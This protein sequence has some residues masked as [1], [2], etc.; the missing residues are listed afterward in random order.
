MPPQG[1]QT[2]GTGYVPRVKIFFLILLFICLAGVLASLFA[3]VFGLVKGGGDPRRSNRLMRYR[4][5]F[6]AAALVIL[7]ILFLLGRP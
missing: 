4:V 3:G 5:M 2:A 1:A 6:Q 7:A